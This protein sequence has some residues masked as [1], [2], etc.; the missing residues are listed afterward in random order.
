MGT[1]TYTSLPDDLV[2]TLLSM[3]AGVGLGI[4]MPHCWESHQWQD[5]GG[6]APDL[7]WDPSERSRLGA[8]F[9]RSRP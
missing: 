6:A 3:G 8:C 4:T 2:R 1:L 9:P 7:V 5:L